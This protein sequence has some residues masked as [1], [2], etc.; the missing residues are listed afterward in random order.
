[1]NLVPCSKHC[2]HQREGYCA[3]EGISEPVSVQEKECSFFSPLPLKDAG[4]GAAQIRSGDQP[5]V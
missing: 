4:K 5:D 2:R 1:M 3:L